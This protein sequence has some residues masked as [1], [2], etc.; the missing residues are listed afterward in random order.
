M[1]KTIILIACAILVS[2]FSGCRPGTQE[3]QGGGVDTVGI[4]TPVG[5]DQ[6]CLAAVDIFVDAS[7]SMK[8]YID[9]V[10]STFK[11]VVPGLIPNLTNIDRMGLVQDSINCYTIVNSQLKKQDTNY[12]GTSITTASI[13]NG[14]STE[15]HKMIEVVAQ[16]VVNMPEHVGIIVSDCVLSFS[17]KELKSDREKNYNDIAILQNS[18]TNAM[19]TL[20]NNNM[21]VS[22]VKYTSEFNGNYYYDYH[23]QKLSLGQGAIMKDRPYYLIL[24]GKRNLVDAMFDKNAIPSECESVFTFNKEGA[25]PNFMLYRAKIASTWVP[26]LNGNVPTIAT[27]VT[28]NPKISAPYIYITI[29][30]FSI[31]P[32]FDKRDSVKI[33]NSPRVDGNYIASVDRVRQDVVASDLI[34]VKGDIPDLTGKNIYKVTFKDNATLKNLT[35]F[36]DRIYFEVPEVDAASSEI[37]KDDAQSLT[38]LSELEGK[39]F[40]FNHLIKALRNAYSNGGAPLAEVEITIKTRNSNKQ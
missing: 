20:Y 31:P 26:E 9:G 39:T 38:D 7:G 21:T 22:V 15:L 27:Y 37:E 30:G 13:F 17:D 34:K 36:S 35:T 19:T 33:M 32:Y 16:S 8:G 11:Q 4:V 6:G 29:D 24:V 25:K 28:P 3:H 10:Q 2:C 14:Q 1:K 18:V 40:M 23:N 5:V 12:F